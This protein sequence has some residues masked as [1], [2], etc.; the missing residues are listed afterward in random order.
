MT[1][2][3]NVHD[4]YHY[5]E[6]EIR[7]PRAHGSEQQYVLLSFPGDY[8]RAAM[9]VTHYSHEQHDDVSLANHHFFSSLLFFVRQLENNAW[10]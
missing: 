9:P 7:L 8:D 5:Q 1:S 3:N 2:I 4:Y 6:R 10:H